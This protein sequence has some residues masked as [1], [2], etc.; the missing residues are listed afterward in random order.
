MPNTT[1]VSFMHACIQHY[2]A[3]IAQ[4]YCMKYQGRKRIYPTEKA[5]KT[6]EE[7]KAAIK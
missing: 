3:R 6:T 5:P 1:I 4:G 7:I 2:L